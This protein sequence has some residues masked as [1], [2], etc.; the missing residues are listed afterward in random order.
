MV[1]QL[2]FVSDTVEHVEK[3]LRS[4]VGQS[5]ETLDA[6]VNEVG[7]QLVDRFRTGLENAYSSS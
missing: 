7:I 1:E 5:L 6:L 2:T 4:I 3:L